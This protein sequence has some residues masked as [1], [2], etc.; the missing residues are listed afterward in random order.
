[1]GRGGAAE[2]VARLQA[3]ILSEGI[4]EALG[5]YL[6]TAANMLQ[7]INENGILSNA[8][9]TSVLAQLTSEGDIPEQVAKSFQDMQSA[10]SGAQG[11]A[12]AFFQQAFTREGIGGGM[13][14]ATR[15]A[16]ESGLFGVNPDRLKGFGDARGQMMQNLGAEGLGI[17][18]QG[19]GFRERSSAILRELKE[20]SGIEAG[21]DLR[22]ITPQQTLTLGR[23]AQQLGLGKD[24]IGSLQNIFR[25]RA[26]ERGALTEEEFKKQFE[27]T[28]KT[29]ELKNL[30]KIAA[31]GAGQIDALNNLHTTIR[32]QLGGQLVPIAKTIQSTL[33]NAD[34]TLSGIGSFFG[35][36]SEG[37]LAEQKEME[38]SVKGLAESGDLEK[39]FR[40]MEEREQSEKQANIDLRGTRPTSI[41]ARKADLSLPTKDLKP[42]EP[43]SLERPAEAKADKG[44]ESLF[45]EMM[46]V[47]K[48]MTEN[49][50][51]LVQI[52]E[53]IAS[54]PKRKIILSGD[55]SNKVTE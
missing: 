36:E 48:Q 2:A 22:N 20:R 28:Q 25:L 17:I 41:S 27:E 15:A 6:E 5:P 33:M 46:S 49:T 29:P 53:N 19:T 14:G 12:Q 24:F 13:V 26:A 34:R 38:E 11:Q 55:R 3:S 10:I 23:L 52:N 45:G 47:F 50:G 43:V 39:V 40:G 4:E 54:K 18:G 8:E 16:V 35:V 21:E 42:M 32:D 7:S 44:L 31:S 30:D 1:M 37:E 51:K 9:I